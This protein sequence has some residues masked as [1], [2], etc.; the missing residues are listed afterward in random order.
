MVHH[1]SRNKSARCVAEQL[2]C[3][4]YRAE[5]GV[6]QNKK[7]NRIISAVWTV[8]ITGSMTIN[9]KQGIEGQRQ[10]ER[11]LSCLSD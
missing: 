8:T 5:N 6:V 7:E 4:V 9:N 11:E 10:N 2:S 1:L 3:I